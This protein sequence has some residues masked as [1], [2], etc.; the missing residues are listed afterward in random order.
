VTSSS[1]L[2]SALMPISSSTI[3]PRIMMAA[4]TR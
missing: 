1:D 4:P 2:P 3:P